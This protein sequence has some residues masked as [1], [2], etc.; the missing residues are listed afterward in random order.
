MAHSTPSS[1]TRPEHWS[2]PESRAAQ[3][4]INPEFNCLIAL[5]QEFVS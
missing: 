1:A 5:T 2:T 3:I 4:D